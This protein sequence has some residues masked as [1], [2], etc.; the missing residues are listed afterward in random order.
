MTIRMKKIAVLAAVV[1]VC[2]LGSGCTLK[3]GAPWYNPNSYVYHNPFGSPKDHPNALAG[4]ETD[5]SVLDAKR[6]SLESQP[7]I[8]TPAAGY[9]HNEAPA[10]AG[11]VGTPNGAPVAG[12][13]NSVPDTAYP[14]VAH[15]PAQQNPHAALPNTSAAPNVGAYPGYPQHNPSVAMAGGAYTNVDGAYEPVQQQPYQ[16]QAYQQ[17]AY[18]QQVYP[19]YQ[20]AATDPAY[21]TQQAAYPAYSDPAYQQQPV[22][23]AAHP[24]VYA[25]PQVPA[26]PAMGTPMDQQ[27]P[28][29]PYYPVEQQQGAGP[30]QLRY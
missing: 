15:Q 30:Y 21:A 4:H 23:A 1:A 22:A 13:N 26:M 28:T 14:S 19:P 5:Q 20:A 11:T 27:Q 3:T 7:N 10:F 29:T 25:D 8:K 24:G 2:G 6:P 18:Q 12:V 9:S 16:Q 17:P